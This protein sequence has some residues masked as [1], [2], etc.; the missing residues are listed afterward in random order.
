V[1]RARSPP[2]AASSHDVA[3]RAAR[4]HAG[5]LCRVLGPAATLTYPTQTANRH[6]VDVM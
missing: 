2:G 5:A 1:L 4:A 6:E 3:V